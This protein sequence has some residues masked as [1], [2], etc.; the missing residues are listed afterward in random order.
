MSRRRPARS[1][2]IIYTG[3]A[4]RMDAQEAMGSD[5]VRGI[6]ELVTNSDDAYE[7]SGTGGGKIWIGIDHAHK[8]HTRR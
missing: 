4:F 3:R 8:V 2:Q 5:I 6:I 1:G 7:R